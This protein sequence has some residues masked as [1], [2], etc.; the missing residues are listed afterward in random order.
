MSR[1]ARPEFDGKINVVCSPTVVVVLKRAANSEESSSKSV[2]AVDRPSVYVAV[3]T[4]PAF[5]LLV[6]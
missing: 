6:E 5:C 3:A 2:D 4:R 1:P